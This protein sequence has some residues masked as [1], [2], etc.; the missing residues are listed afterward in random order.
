VLGTLALFGIFRLGQRM[1]GDRTALLAMILGVSSPFYAYLA[2]SYLSHAVALCF[3]VYFLWFLIRFSDTHR[4]R[5]AV[6]AV[7]CLVAMFCTRE[8]SAVLVGV[9]AVSWIVWWRRREFRDD[10]IH[11]LAVGVVGGVL[12]T[13]GLVVYLSYNAAQTGDP[14]LLPRLLFFP[15][16][17][18][19]FGAGIGFYG[20]HTLA[21]GL[22]ILD[23]L[24]TSLLIDLFGW[25]F[26]ITLA[27]IPLAMLR[28]D[29]RRMWDWFALTCAAVLIAAQ[30]GYFYHGIFLGPRYLY[31]SLPFLLL[32]TA[33]GFS[34][35]TSIG[36]TVLKHVRS[37]SLGRHYGAAAQCAA[38]GICG[39][40][41][42]FNFAFYLPRQISQHSNFTGL[43]AAIPIDAA[44]IYGAQLQN[45]LVVTDNWMIYNYVLWPLNDPDLRASV[46]Y[47]YAP[48]TQAVERLAHEY[49]GRSLLELSVDASGRVSFQ[50]VRN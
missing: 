42:V 12:L 40:L 25:P 23:Q 20:R 13:L 26:Y 1:Y 32:L 14:F 28:H 24:S 31:E 38:S 2:A 17:R 50:P 47:A 8:F 15:A 41:L 19:G 9:I 29:G 11:V 22:V 48:T 16:D 6:I 43:P 18:Y 39:V 36:Q 45:A 30:A 27:L 34:A 21:A 5:H 49:P 35:I 3:E 10:L 46:L 44:A 37:R 7:A 33:R 4:T